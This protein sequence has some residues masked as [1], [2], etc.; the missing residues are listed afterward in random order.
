MRVFQRIP[1]FTVDLQRIQQCT[2][3]VKAVAYHIGVLL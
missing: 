1:L 2:E 3:A